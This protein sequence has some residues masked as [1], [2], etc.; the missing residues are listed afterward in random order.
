MKLSDSE[1]DNELVDTA[2]KHVSTLLLVDVSDE[3]HRV[4]GL[5]QNVFVVVVKSD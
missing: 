2:F 1:A 3:R 4:I 5:S